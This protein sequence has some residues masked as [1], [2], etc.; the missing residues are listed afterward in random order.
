MT[1][2]GAGMTAANIDIQDYDFMGRIVK[3]KYGNNVV[4]H[5]RY[6]YDTGR[7]TNIIAGFQGAAAFSVQNMAY[8]Y[9]ILSNLKT[10]LDSNTGVSE[11]FSYDSL[12]RLSLYTELGGSVSPPLS[13]ETKYD[14]RGNLIYKSDVGQYWYDAARP[15]RLTNIT[16][17]APSGTTALTGTRKLA[18]AFDD[19]LAG[20]KTANGTTLGNG[21]L[22]YTVSQDTAN[23]KHTV[24]FETYTSFN[25]PKEIK[26]A[27]IGATEAPTAAQV[28]AKASDRTLSFVYG[29]EHQR[30][31][32][33]TTLTGNGTSAYS[34]VPDLRER[35]QDFGSDST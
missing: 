23:S 32:Q 29:S 18:F 9:D 11:T 16:L 6:A 19:Y 35:N 4:T 8:S 14:T 21:N 5:K 26:Y 13:V 3:Y 1:A 20:A 34:A 2:S 7:L 17:S 22:M 12:N 27:N 15:N 30:I 25:M 24:R 28:Y 33:I 31:K 10:R